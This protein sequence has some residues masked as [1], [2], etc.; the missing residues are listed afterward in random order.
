MEDTGVSGCC[1]PDHTFLD[2]SIHAFSSV[3]I[4]EDEPN[5]GVIDNIKKEEPL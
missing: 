3:D 5:N 2:N 4:Q 1:Y